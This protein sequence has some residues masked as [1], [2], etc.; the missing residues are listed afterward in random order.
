M[1]TASFFIYQGPGRIS[2]ARFG[3]RTKGHRGYRR[4]PA[5]APRQ[6]ML[7]MSYEQYRPQYFAILDA[8][9]PKTVWDELHRLAEPQEPVLLCWERGPLTATNWCHRTL[10][11]EWF[12]RELAVKVPEILAFRARRRSLQVVDAGGS[13]GSKFAYVDPLYPRARAEIR[14]WP[15]LLRRG[16]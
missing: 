13:D 6:D 4:Y 8:L 5:L 3:H 16:G 11:A 12:E 15:G 1:K 14:R 10:V 2:I 7:R 9:D